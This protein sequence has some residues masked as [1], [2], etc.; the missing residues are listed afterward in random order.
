[1]VGTRRHRL[2][3]SPGCDL[4]R[5]ELLRCRSVQRSSSHYRWGSLSWQLRRESSGCEFLQIPLHGSVV[6]RRE[7]PLERH[8][9]VCCQCGRDGCARS[10]RLGDQLG[11]SASSDRHECGRS[12]G[13][14]VSPDRRAQ[15][16]VVTRSEPPARLRVRALLLVAVRRPQHLHRRRGYRHCRGRVIG[17][18]SLGSPLLRSRLCDVGGDRG[19][20]SMA[21]AVALRPLRRQAAQR[22]V[23][24]RRLLRRSTDPAATTVVVAGSCVVI[25]AGIAATALVATQATGSAIPDTLTSALIG[26]LLSSPPSSCCTRIVSSSPVGA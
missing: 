17:Q 24:L 15:Q 8:R 1:M 6:Q 5:R 20:G 11:S 21:L 23:R 16:R 26:V 19:S 12:S 14:G 13:P 18:A 3:E 25:G 4:G 9:L 7:D 2:E 22:G 10:Q